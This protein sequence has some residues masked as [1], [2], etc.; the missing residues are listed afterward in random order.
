GQLR[1]D[2]AGRLH[3]RE[4]LLLVLVGE[5]E[6]GQRVLA[7]DH[8]RRQRRSATGGER[9]QGVRGALQLQAHPADL[10]DHRGQ[11][12]CGD[13]ATDERDHRA[14]PAAWAATAAW[15]RLVA[16]PRQMWQIASAS[17]SA[18]SAGLGTASSRS[19]RATID[20]TCALSARPLPVTAALTSLGVCM[21]TGMPRAAAATSASPLTC[22]VPITVFTLA[23]E[24]TRSTA[25]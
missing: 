8:A 1:P 19:N 11:P 16:G 5:A 24:K 4:H 12:D 17:A 3:Q 15:I 7:D 25:I 6:E 20:P 21:V 13:P 23:W 10:E 9:R 14:A 22:A 2:A 18:A